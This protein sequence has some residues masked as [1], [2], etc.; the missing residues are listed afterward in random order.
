MID[1]F[2]LIK[3]QYFISNEDCYIRK[4]EMI[5]FLNE[6]N[7]KY[8]IQSTYDKDLQCIFIYLT[9][10]SRVQILFYGDIISNIFLE[11][12]DNFYLFKDN[13]IK[14]NGID[15]FIKELE[16]YNIKWIFKEIIDDKI[17]ILEVSNLLFHFNYNVFS[18]LYK[19]TYKE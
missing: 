8:D 13:K 12:Y 16:K 2:D 5:I 17:I 7:I 1:L 9:K 3:K 18:Y 14:N 4:E 11:I 6:N 15:T 10:K 19:V